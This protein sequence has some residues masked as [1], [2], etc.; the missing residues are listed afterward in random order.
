MC[1]VFAINLKPETLAAD[2]VERMER[3]LGPATIKE[4]YLKYW[5]WETGVLK[6]K[7]F[8]IDGVLHSLTVHYLPLDHQSDD[9]STLTSWTR[10]GTEEQ[11][12]MVP[13]GDP[14]GA[15]ERGT[16]PDGSD[17]PRQ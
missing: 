9:W 6:A 14:L 3:Q 7:V 10:P 2:F 15:H 8:Q 5:E 11:F 4:G 13:P 1:R 12:L 16:E 17:G